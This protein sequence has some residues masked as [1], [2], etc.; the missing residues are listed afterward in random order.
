[1]IYGLIEKYQIAPNS[2][3]GVRQVSRFGQSGSVQCSL[4]DHTT[5]L[6]N[7]LLAAKSRFLLNI[8]SKDFT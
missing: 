3:G 5:E 2:V 7:K 8:I 1:M 6:V 4:R